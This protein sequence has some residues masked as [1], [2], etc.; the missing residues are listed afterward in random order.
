MVTK[1][2]YSENDKNQKLKYYDC[3]TSNEF[4]SKIKKQQNSKAQIAT[5]LK[6]QIVINHKNSNSDKALKLKL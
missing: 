6:T 4:G 2:K 5:N 3:D 1:L